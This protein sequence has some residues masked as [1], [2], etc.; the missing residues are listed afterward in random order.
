MNF[1]Q[2]I[3]NSV[4]GDVDDNNHNNN[5]G[6]ES[7]SEE[8]TENEFYTV[9]LIY[10]TGCCDGNFLYFKLYRPYIHLYTVKSF[11]TRDYCINPSPSLYTY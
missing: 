5:I 2:R 10:L 3:Y 9:I 7:S 8:N 1:I 11:F 4:F 6:Q